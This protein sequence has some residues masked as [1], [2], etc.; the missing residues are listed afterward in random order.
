MRNP[1]GTDGGAERSEKMWYN[2]DTIKYF[3]YIEGT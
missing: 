2:Y 1:L 3:M